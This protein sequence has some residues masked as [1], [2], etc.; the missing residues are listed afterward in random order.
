[1]GAEGMQKLLENTG[2]GRASKG[3][4]NKRKLEGPGSETPKE[5]SK[6]WV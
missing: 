3:K 4:S 5:A 6:V 1:M 2:G